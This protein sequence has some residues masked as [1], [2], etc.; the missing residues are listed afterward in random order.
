MNPSSMEVG[1]KP[2]RP[3]EGK[4]QFPNPMSDLITKRGDE[5]ELSKS[6]NSHFVHF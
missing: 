3:V 2:E 5:Y 4:T 1:E 6:D